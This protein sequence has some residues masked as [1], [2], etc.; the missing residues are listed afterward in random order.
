MLKLYW[1]ESIDDCKECVVKEACDRG[2]LDLGCLTG[3]IYQIREESEEPAKETAYSLVLKTHTAL[4]NIGNKEDC[5]LRDALLKYINENKPKPEEKWERCT[6]ENTK[7]LDEV[8]GA[9]SGDMYIVK[10]IFE[11]SKMFVVKDKITG[12]DGNYIFLMKNYEINTA[13]EK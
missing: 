6:K 8:R 5:D 10:Y 1:D 9:F 12:S 2:E 11:S 4:F 7:V 13:K 3:G